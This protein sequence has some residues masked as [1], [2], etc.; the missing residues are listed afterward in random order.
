MKSNHIAL[1]F[2]VLNV[3]NRSGWK[4]V[5]SIPNDWT[6]DAVGIGNKTT[7]KKCYEDLV[8]WEFIKW[9][10]KSKNQYTANRIEIC[11]NKNEPALTQALTQAMYQQCASNE[12]SSEQALQ[13]Y[14]NNINIKTINILNQQTIKMELY[15]NKKDI[16]NYEGLNTSKQKLIKK[17]LEKILK[18]HLELLSTEDL[19]ENAYDIE[20]EQKNAENLPAESQTTTDLE[21]QILD[22]FGVSEL[23]N[24]RLFAKVRQFLN[25]LGDN[26][27]VFKKNFGYYKI[28]KDMTGEHIHSLENF[29]GSPE[30][31]YQDGA[32]CSVNFKYKLKQYENN[33][34]LKQN[35]NSKEKDQTKLNQGKID[36]VNRFLNENY[37]DYEEE[38]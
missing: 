3:A 8:N 29:I 37:D 30:Q 13:P 24:Y 33:L 26:L 14:I 22:Y 20:F 28:Y 18:D 7:L 4:R 17:N 27:E 34:H 23:N 11:R 15:F 10:E 16:E 6:M 5:L 38:Q 35:Q 9:V 12:N 2:W 21:N 36:I 25:S 31:H 19:S 1:L 32:W